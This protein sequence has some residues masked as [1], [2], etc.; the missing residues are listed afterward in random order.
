MQHTDKNYE[1]QI[2][3]IN[4]NLVKMGSILEQQFSDALKVVASRDQ[5]LANKVVEKD[6]L[7]NQLNHDISDLV[8]QIIAMRQPMADDL[9]FLFCSIKIIRDLERIGDHLTTHDALNCLFE[10]KLAQADQI[11]E[12]DDIIDTLHGNF[13]KDVLSYMKENDD[14]IPDSLALIQISKGIER[15]G[16]YVTN[17]MEE[18][19]FLIEGKYNNS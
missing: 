14:F 2:N 12:R 6:D 8:F 7:I 1:N 17:I 18:V 15:I 10:R 3:L 16:D 19:H 5:N 4:E 11:A 13:I 9:R